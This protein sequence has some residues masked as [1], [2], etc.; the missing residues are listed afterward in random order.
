MC[1]LFSRYLIEDNADD[2]VI[3]DEN[4]KQ[5]TVM[6]I[7]ILKSALNNYKPYELQVEE[8]LHTEVFKV[9][10]ILSNTNSFVV[11]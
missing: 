5:E 2:L 11:C 8:E 3:F 10:L 7:S 6:I 4:L 9:T 1:L